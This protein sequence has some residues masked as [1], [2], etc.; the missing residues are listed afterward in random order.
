[1]FTNK[2]H[3][4]RPKFFWILS[5]NL[6]IYISQWCILSN[7]FEKRRVHVSIKIIFK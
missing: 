6:I 2:R 7:K 4:C 1:M 3:Q 5:S